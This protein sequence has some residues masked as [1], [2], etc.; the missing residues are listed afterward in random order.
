MA[1]KVETLSEEEA[2]A[3]ASAV[4]RK[5]GTHLPVN[6]ASAFQELMKTYNKNE[7]PYMPFSVLEI[8]GLN[9]YSN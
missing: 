2:K 3:L 7:S 1:T 9:D 8:L 5:D 6:L 4:N